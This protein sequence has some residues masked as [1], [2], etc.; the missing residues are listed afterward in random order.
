LITSGYFHTTA[1][2]EVNFKMSKF[3]KGVFRFFG[4]IM[5]KEQCVLIRRVCMSFFS[6]FMFV[7][8]RERKRRGER[9]RE[10][11]RERKG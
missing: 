8:V 2:L 10:R 1:G 11:E 9:E 4:P 7:G 3:K 6:F 5:P